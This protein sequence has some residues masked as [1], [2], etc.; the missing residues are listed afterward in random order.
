M[1]QSN[2]GN[3]GLQS[4]RI[5]TT[6]ARKTRAERMGTPTPTKQKVL[7]NKNQLITKN[8]IELEVQPPVRVNYTQTPNLYKSGTTTGGYASSFSITPNGQAN[9]NK[10]SNSGPGMK[11][12]KSIKILKE[13]EEPSPVP[14]VTSPEFGGN[15]QVHR[16]TKTKI[17]N[18]IKKIKTGYQI[19]VRRINRLDSGPSDVESAVSARSLKSNNT[20]KFTNPPKEIMVPSKKENK[21]PLKKPLV[22]KR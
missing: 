17:E 4:K 3:N 10:F 22:T 18:S 1:N 11:T 15:K 16:S 19:P 12:Y 6:Q 5:T 20:T 9:K 21:I 7:K 8:K 13:P 2:G 14:N